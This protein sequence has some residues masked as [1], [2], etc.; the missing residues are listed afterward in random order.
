M[1]AILD[2]LEMPRGT[3]LTFIEKEGIDRRH[4]VLEISTDVNPQGSYCG[5]V[6]DTVTGQMLWTGLWTISEYMALEEA[7]YILNRLETI[8]GF[9]S[10]SLYDDSTRLH[11]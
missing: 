10:I 4:T 11:A 6:Y 9:G 3:Y 5:L 2:E 8:Q 7:E 1:N